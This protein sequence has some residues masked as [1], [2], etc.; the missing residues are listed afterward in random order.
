[1]RTN[2]LP[3]FLRWCTF[4]E[5]DAALLED[6]ERRRSVY[7]INSVPTEPYDPDRATK[8]SEHVD[9]VEAVFTILELEKRRDTRQEVRQT[10]FISELETYRRLLEGGKRQPKAFQVFVEQIAPTAEIS[11]RNEWDPTR[12]EML[13][14]AANGCRHMLESLYRERI[15]AL[16]GPCDTTVKCSRLL[17]DVSPRRLRY[18]A[19]EYPGLPEICQK[20]CGVLSYRPEPADNAVPADVKQSYGYSNKRKEFSHLTRADERSRI[21]FL[22]SGGVF[23]GSFHIGVI[24]AM[25]AVKML[26]DLV[27]GASVGALMG[28]AL[29]AISALSDQKAE[30]L[31]DELASTFLEVDKRVAL[32]STL[33]NAV[34]ELGVRAREITL[35]PAEVRRMVLRGSRADPGYAATGAPPALI[36][37]ISRL[38]V[39]P[40][41]RTA[42]IASSFVAGHTTEAVN[43]F[44]NEIRKNTCQSRYP[45]C[46]DGHLTPIAKSPGSPR[47]Q[48]RSF[49]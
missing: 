48:R 36:D 10:N 15:A 47:R 43:Q 5:N 16:R 21:V 28:G 30:L 17:Q 4:H 39:I 23:R 24:A 7:V 44:L 34:R 19:A 41:R 1:M 18:I 20:C 49:S 2:P 3:A 32:T 11:F 37:A 22:G 12:S 8:Q 14:V 45:V 40:H 27:I 33:K 6:P 9:I 25:K 35:S 26:P 29:A 42:A 13:A 46:P 31:L 38:F